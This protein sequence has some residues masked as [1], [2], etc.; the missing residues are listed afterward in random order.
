MVGWQGLLGIGPRPAPGGCAPPAGPAAGLRR[1]VAPHCGR[2]AVAIRG[3]F[4]PVSIAKW[5]YALWAWRY[6]AR[7]SSLRY[8]DIAI[9]P[10]MKARAPAASPR[11]PRLPAPCVRPR[12][13]LELEML[14]KHDPLATGPCAA[15][16]RAGQCGGRYSFMWGAGR[17]KASL[18][19]ISP[20]HAGQAR[21]AAR[22]RP[23]P[24][25]R[26]RQHQADDEDL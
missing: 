22:A 13:D 7:R 15:V 18:R 23:G 5:R 12:R 9:S 25:Q 26:S 10:L 1:A 24:P 17:R 6:A 20:R 19:H 14:I 2:T 21:A 4:G 11:P 8:R 16:V 3:P